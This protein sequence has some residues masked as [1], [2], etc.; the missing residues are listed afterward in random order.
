MHIGLDYT[1]ALRQRA[2]IGRYT[3]GMVS[4]LATL[5]TQNRYSLVIPRDCIQ[6][7]ALGSNRM[8]VCRLPLTDWSL[9]IIWHRLRLPLYVDAFTGPLDVFHSPDFVL[10]PLR[11]GRTIVTVHDL[12]FIRYPECADRGL[13]AY[14]SVV[15]PRSLRRADLIL[16][17]SAWTRQDIVTLLGI[18]AEKIVVVPAGVSAEYH[19]INDSSILNAA[20]VR[21]RLP[22]RFILH[23][24]TLEPRKNLVRLLQAFQ[25]IADQEPEIH[26]V[27]VGSKGWLYQDIFAS[28]ERL[29][30]AQRVVFP[31]YV[32]D[33]DLPAIYNLAT[34]FAYP[35]LY[36]GFGIPP[37]EA[38]ACGVPVV[39][40]NSSSLP[41][42]VGD[43]AVQVEPTDT[44]ALAAALLRLL[45][46]DTLRHS[47][48][49]R[50]LARARLFTWEAAAQTLL[51]VY[52]RVG[53]GHDQTEDTEQRRA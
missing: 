18:P 7:P 40:S 1:S 36:E 37:L 27:L 46:D 43:A 17:D 8:Q 42:V 35:S 49:S 16:A 4:A 20:R 22:G 19:P 25:R 53:H 45:S 9:T 44:D 48:R 51:R 11:S 3:R 5:D 14:L 24:G 6:P 47:L 2:G 30:L 31:G 28:V 41:E 26:L 52:A 15:V 33:A 29:R 23:V 13:V 38:M 50:G 39:C 10:P 21:Y 32:A 12:S 34:V